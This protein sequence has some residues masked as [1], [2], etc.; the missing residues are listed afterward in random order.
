MLNNNER[1]WLCHGFE[2]EQKKKKK[3]TRNHVHIF[4]IYK[5]T[6]NYGI[7][8][9]YQFWLFIVFFLR[10]CEQI[11]DEILAKNIILQQAAGYSKCIK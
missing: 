10:N 8:M 9:V 11:A 3:R 4:G 7:E 1:Y 2:K 6:T 5:C